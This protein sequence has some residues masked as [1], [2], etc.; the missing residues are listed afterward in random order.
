MGFTGSC[1]VTHKFAGESDGGTIPGSKAGQRQLWIMRFAI[2]RKTR[3][4]HVVSR[5]ARLLCPP[6]SQSPKRMIEF[7]FIWEV[8]N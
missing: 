6:L 3:T 2:H 1:I 8:V 5:G 7:I 4:I